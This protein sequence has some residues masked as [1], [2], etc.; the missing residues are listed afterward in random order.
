MAAFSRD[1]YY[2]EDDMDFLTD[3]EEDLILESEEDSLSSVCI[4]S[5]P[6]TVD[7][8]ACNGPKCPVGFYH[9]EC[10]SLPCSASVDTSAG[11][12]TGTSLVDPDLDHWLC[13]FCQLDTD[14]GGAKST[15]ESSAVHAST[16]ATCAPSEGSAATSSSGDFPRK[17]TTD[18]RKKRRQTKTKFGALQNLE[19]VKSK[20]ALVFKE[21]VL[22]LKSN[23][24][25][26]ETEVGRKVI[27]LADEINFHSEIVEGSVRDI[28]QDI[29]EIISA[30]EDKAA[31]PVANTFI[32]TKFQTYKCGSRATQ[33]CLAMLSMEEPSIPFR[34][35]QQYVLRVVLEKLMKIIRG[36]GFEPEEETSP[37][38]VHD[39]QVLRYVAGYIPYALCKKFGRMKS[40]SAL[41]ITAFLREWKKDDDDNTESDTFLQYTSVWLTFQNR[42]G[43]FVVSDTV[44]KLFRSLELVTR[45]LLTLGNSETESLKDRLLKHI[46]GSV[47][48]QNMWCKV[49]GSLDTNLSEPLF[50]SIVNYWVKIRISSYVKLYV[51]SLKREAK[52]ATGKKKGL[53]REL[54][55]QQ[56]K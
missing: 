36:D 6:S 53:R 41:A 27:A 50:S 33:L 24:F 16:E 45:K 44:Y 17:T 7:L 46:F 38:S 26:Q 10:V 40:Q 14:K 8:I 18:T 23:E 20:S 4:C 25:Y 43:L 49:A 34:F 12:G 56:K 32:L 52:I 3:I 22:Q 19:E 21:A 51:S 31:G 30:A 28:V 13:G 54:K 9:R 47:H 48:V 42:G 35:L 2:L 15:S 29:V 37:L 1:D 11:A 5:L 39:E 55:K